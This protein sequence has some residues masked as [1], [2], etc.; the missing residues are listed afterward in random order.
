MGKS[1]DILVWTGYPGMTK[2]DWSWDILSI[3]GWEDGISWE[4]GISW[5][6]LDGL[7]ILGWEDG[8][9]WDYQDG[10]VPGIIYKTRIISW[11]GQD[12]QIEPPQTHYTYLATG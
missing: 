7:G 1:W 11:D 4:A 9:S 6:G 3:L 8:I 12:G 10:L 2:M 5:D